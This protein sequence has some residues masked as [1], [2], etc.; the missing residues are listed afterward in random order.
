MMVKLG[1]KIKYRNLNTGTVQK[2]YLQSEIGDM[3]GIGNHYLSWIKK[4]NIQIIKEYD[5]KMKR[6]LGQDKEVL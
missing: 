4:K 5:G 1:D 3:V 2:G 6:F